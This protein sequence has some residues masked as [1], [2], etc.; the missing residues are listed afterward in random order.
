MYLLFAS[1]SLWAL[2]PSAQESGHHFCFYS[3][4]CVVGNDSFN[5]PLILSLLWFPYTPCL[6]PSASDFWYLK[7]LEFRKLFCLVL[8]I[9]NLVFKTI[10]FLYTFW[11][12]SWKSRLNAD[13]FCPWFLSAYPKAMD[14]SSFM[15]RKRKQ[16]NSWKNFWSMS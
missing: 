4:F 3:N 1:N 10:T 16:N 12:L 14:A 13:F 9:E 5:I 2:Y 6:S 8:A 7:I 15:L 11:S